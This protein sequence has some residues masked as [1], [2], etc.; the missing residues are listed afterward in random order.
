M[1]VIAE[2]KLFNLWFGQHS[3]MGIPCDIW[4]HVIVGFGIYIG[5]LMFG[6]SR[7]RAFELVIIG[8]VLKELTLDLNVLIYTLN[9]FEPLKD[10][11]FTLFGGSLGVFL[12][13][14][15]VRYPVRR[16]RRRKTIYT[17]SL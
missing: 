8:A 11:T 10:I 1:E 4:A 7:N 15:N 17:T 14:G 6:L 5:S 13:Q 9:I 16:R 2:L 3:L 12:T